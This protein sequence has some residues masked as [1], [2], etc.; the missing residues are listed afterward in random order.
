MDG[1]FSPYFL[2]RPR[3]LLY[4]PLSSLPI[5]SLMLRDEIGEDGDDE[6]GGSKRQ[7]LENPKKDE[8]EEKG[9]KCLERSRY[10][11]FKLLIMEFV[12]L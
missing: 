3:A 1:V 7:N 5:L 6:R 8:I 2:Q 11:F 4:F 12:L 9:T 10:V